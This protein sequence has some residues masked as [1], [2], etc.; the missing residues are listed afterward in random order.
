MYPSF[1]QIFRSDGLHKRIVK[2]NDNMN[3]FYSILDGYVKNLTGT[4]LSNSE[5][6]DLFTDY[7]TGTTVISEYI[8]STIQERNFSAI[9]ADNFY[10]GQ[11]TL[12]EVIEN[13]VESNSSVSSDTIGN[14]F[15]LKSWYN[16]VDPGFYYLDVNHNLDTFDV[17]VSVW[18]EDTN[19]DVIPSEIERVNENTV[20]IIVD[21]NDYSLRCSIQKSFTSN[22]PVS[23]VENIVTRNLMTFDFYSTNPVY[24]EVFNI[25]NTIETGYVTPF[26]LV[27]SHITVFI[28]NIEVTSTTNS[29]NI[30]LREVSDMDP[31][32]ESS[33]IEKYS[34]SIVNVPTN[35]NSRREVYNVESF[36][37]EFSAG[38]LMIISVSDVPDSISFDEVVVK[39]F[40]YTT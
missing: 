12:V 31:V 25:G 10:S 7:L 19:R 33:G 39:V 14:V 8:E 1:Q 11:T 29:F 26:D 36:D 38:N 4:T 32:N 34:A 9:T 28:K 30:S 5:V 13:I 2:H 27:V 16:Y 37:Y 20:R 22:S 15:S 18:D 23:I 24:G 17:N 40:G 3:A 21:R 6:H 35:Q